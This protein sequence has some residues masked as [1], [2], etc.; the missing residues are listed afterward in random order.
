MPRVLR[1][2]NSRLQDANLSVL[3]SIKMFFFGFVGNTHD[4]IKEI[5]S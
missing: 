1:L 2:N 3:G 5:D 4:K